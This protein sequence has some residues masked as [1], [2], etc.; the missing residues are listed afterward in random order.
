MSIP[1]AVKFFFE[2]LDETALTRR[3]T[4]FPLGKGFL[5][6]GDIIRRGAGRRMQRCRCQL[7]F[8]HYCKDDKMTIA[9]QDTNCRYVTVAPGQHVNFLRQFYNTTI[10]FNSLYEVTP[11]RRGKEFPCGTDFL[12]RGD[13]IRRGAG[14]RMQRCHCQLIFVRDC[15]DNRMT[16]VAKYTNYRYVTVVPG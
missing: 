1:S 2:S 12:E 5:E 10:F 6:R 8:V 3:G 15:K 9:E 14:R 7:S 16:I 4:E 11:T 13:I